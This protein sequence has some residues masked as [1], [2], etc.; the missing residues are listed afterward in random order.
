MG[1]FLLMTFFFNYSFEPFN[2][3]H[4]EHKMNY[5]W[6]SAIHAMT[7]VIV[8]FVLAF[9]ANA[10][11]LE[12]SWNIKKE[13]SFIFLFF[14]FV[15]MVQFLIRDIIYSNP[16]NWS[17]HYLFEEIRNTFLVGAL[18]VLILIPWNFNRLKVKNIR[19]ANTLNSTIAEK[20]VIA[21]KTSDNT[22]RVKIDNQELNLDQLMFVKSEGN[23]LEIHLHGKKPSKTLIR[24]TLKDLEALL[25][26]YPNMI[27]THR[28]YLVNSNYI[29][30]ITGNA[31]GYQLHFSDYV[32]PVSR[33][34]I[35]KF[36]SRIKMA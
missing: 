34:M 27:K 1:L 20:L 15:G 24:S 21:K 12:P 29:E 7:P 16:N 18:F 2:V 14:L 8:L 5:F 13:A 23:Y 32:V 36:N 33:N 3:D 11:K 10:L 6:I 31:Q 19:K 35:A 4:S 22:G 9:V 30:S 17:W 28:S 26:T 25:N